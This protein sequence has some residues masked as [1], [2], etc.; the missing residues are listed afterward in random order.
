MAYYSPDEAPQMVR[1]H[2]VGILPRDATGLDFV[3]QADLETLARIVQDGDHKLLIVDTLGRLFAGSKFPDS[4]QY[5]AW[6][7]G[8]DRVR[9]VAT[10]TKCHVCLLH[11]ARKSGGDRSL[12]VLGS[13]AIAGAADTVI[14]LQVEERD[15]RWARTIQST[16]R[17]GVELAAQSLI[18]AGDG[19][20]DVRPLATSQREREP[21]KSDP[22]KAKARAM[23]ET[24]ASLQEIADGVNV[25]R[26]TVSRWLRGTA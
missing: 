13:A 2:F 20:L 1:E 3:Q 12:A 9:Q 25:H 7:Q 5:M 21:A 23:R 24:G 6:Q 22:R 10:D 26:A 16:Q 15:G 8:L 18:F 19:W 17:A 11:H 14:E 4:D